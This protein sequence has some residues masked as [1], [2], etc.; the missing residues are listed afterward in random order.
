[1]QRRSRAQAFRDLA[2]VE[3]GDPALLVEDRHDEGAVQVFVAARADHAERLEPL[4]DRRP[5]LAV[6]RRQ[7]VAE[8][9]VREAELEV[10]HGLGVLKAR[11]AVH[12]GC[13]HRSEATVGG[14]MGQP[15]FSAPKRFC[16]YL[17]TASMPREPSKR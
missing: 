3:L 16:R 6:L 4:A 2:P 15:T 1:M 7:A 8:R 13:T 12:Q 9:A 17:F 11:R 10:L 14:M 5:L